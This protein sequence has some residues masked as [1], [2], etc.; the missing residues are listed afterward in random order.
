MRF[1][2]LFLAVGPAA[3][4]IAACSGSST[5]TQ[6]AGGGGGSTQG[7]AATTA[8]GGGGGGTEAPGATVVGGGDGGGVGT[9][10]GTMHI[11]ISGPV[12]KSAD[13][14][15]IPLGSIF[16]G[17]AGSA[18]NFAGSDQNNI[19]SIIIGADNA[20]T[21]SWLSSDFQAPATVCTTSNWNIGATSGS[22]SFD[23]TAAVVILASG[24]TVSNA[25]I[26][27]NFTAHA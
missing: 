26:T 18:L 5:P 10:N 2:R 20:V 17:Q 21:I 11:E 12:T 23:C 7:P 1:Q 16:G 24:A 3:L 8:G 13:Y 19:V 4:L 15:F 14:G 6:P 9:Q 22:G 25:K 27:G